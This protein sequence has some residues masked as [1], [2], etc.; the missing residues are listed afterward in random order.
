M[1]ARVIAEKAFG[2]NRREGTPVLAISL[3]ALAELYLRQGKFSE[4][5]SFCREAIAFI[6]RE[7]GKTCP[8]LVV[9]LGNY[10]EVLR[11][12]GRAEEAKEF[13]SRKIALESL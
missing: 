3:N 11:Q 5:E 9:L 13:E 1:R 10:V 12:T 6:E 4:A 2:Q 8:Y 7:Q